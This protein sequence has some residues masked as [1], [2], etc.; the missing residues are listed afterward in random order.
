M[1]HF[2]TLLILASTAMT[3]ITGCG[4][5]QAEVSAGR[6]QSCHAGAGVRGEF[7]RLRELS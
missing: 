6:I 3:A 7:E 5:K 1:R 2:L 4:Q